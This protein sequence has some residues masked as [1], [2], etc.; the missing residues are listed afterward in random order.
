MPE[1]LLV[2]ARTLRE[3]VG[4]R[5]R[6]VAL[7][8]RAEHHFH[9]GRPL[10]ARFC[11]DRPCLPESRSDRRWSSLPPSQPGSGGGGGEGASS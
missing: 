8:P 7:T 6:D 5:Y 10:V 1:D 11:Y 3:Q 2:N 4:D 9:T